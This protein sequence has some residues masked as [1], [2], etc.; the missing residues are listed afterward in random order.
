METQIIADTANAR[1]ERFMHYL[2]TLSSTGLVAFYCE[3]CL[4]RLGM[5]EQQLPSAPF[6]EKTGTCCHCKRAG[7]V[8]NPF[9]NAF[10]NQNG[11][12]LDNTPAKLF[13]DCPAGLIR[14]WLIP[15]RYYT[16]HRTETGYGESDLLTWVKFGRQIAKNAYRS[17]LKEESK[18]LLLAFYPLC[19]SAD[20]FS[21][22]PDEPIVVQAEELSQVVISDDSLP[23][24]VCLPLVESLNSSLTLEMPQQSTFA[25][26]QAFVSRIQISWKGI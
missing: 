17:D 18:E 8:S 11:W 23:E 19:Y 15:A 2:L 12:R 22:A 10:L 3:T 16:F 6:H 5:T 4:E 14:D 25:A 1:V 7:D 13:E 26:I 9:I 21:S 20:R 24:L